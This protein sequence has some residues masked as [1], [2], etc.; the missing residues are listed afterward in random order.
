MN[1]KI[2]VGVAVAVLAVILGGILLVG[3]TMMV[4]SSNDSGVETIPVEQG[5][6]S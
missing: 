2:F 1:P 5:K 6:T 3:P 4:S